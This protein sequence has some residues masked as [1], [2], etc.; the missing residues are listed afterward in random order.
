M[1]NNT[2]LV[3]ANLLVMEELTD[4]QMETIKGGSD[5]V[6][7]DAALKLYNYDTDA[8]VASYGG[9]DVIVG[10]YGYGIYAA[11]GGEPGTGPEPDPRI[12][13][14]HGYEI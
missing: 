2:K 12:H 7:F 14:H 10:I 4:L 11:I 1:K 5:I 9:I 13:H 8:L 3:I 6:E